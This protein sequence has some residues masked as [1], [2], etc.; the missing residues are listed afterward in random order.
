MNIVNMSDNTAAI[1]GI[2]TQGILNDRQSDTDPMANKLSAMGLRI[3]TFEGNQVNRLSESQLVQIAHCYMEVFNESWGESWDEVSALREVKNN[4]RVE[5]GR[6]PMASLLYRGNKLIGFAWGVLLDKDSLAAERDMPFGLHCGEKQKG[7]KVA[8]YWLDNIAKQKKLFL[9]RELGVLK[10]HRKL[11]TP[12]L[13]ISAFKRAISLGYNTALFWTNIDSGAFNWGLGIG[14]TPVHFFI[15]K[16][17]LLMFGSINYAVSVFDTSLNSDLSN[18][19][20]YREFFNN[21]NRY[22]CKDYEK[23][24][25]C[26]TG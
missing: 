24:L 6:T 21:I 19:R 17:L 12:F 9:L 7:L 13:G 22:L 25:H 26:N 1:R 14:L 5:T 18:E 15:K 4:L 10:S 8:Q 11:L 20:R 16:N 2:N 23:S 3:Q